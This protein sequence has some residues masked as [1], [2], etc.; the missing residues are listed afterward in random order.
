MSP[1]VTPRIHLLPSAGPLPAHPNPQPHKS[2]SATSHLSLLHPTADPT[3]GGGGRERE[4]SFTL[5]RT[6]ACRVGGMFSDP[7]PRST[8]FPQS[9]S[10]SSMASLLIQFLTAWSNEDGSRVHGVMIL[11]Y[12][13]LA[14]RKSC[15]E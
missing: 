12:R 3:G 14:G 9:T 6:Q 13:Q 2:Q 5:G 4:V 1:S 11:F 15:V 8:P 10:R 7:S